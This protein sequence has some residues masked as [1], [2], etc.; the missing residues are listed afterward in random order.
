MKVNNFSM[1]IRKTKKVDIDPDAHRLPPDWGAFDEYKVAD[2][3][4]PSTWSNDGYFIPVEEGQPLWIDFRGNRQCAAILSIQRLNPI[5]GKPANLEDGLKKDPEQNYMVLPNQMWIDGY[6]NNGKVYQ[7]V[8]TTAGKSLAVNE[9]LLPPE[10][11]DSH[12]LGVAFYLPR[13]PAPTQAYRRVK[14]RFATTP[15]Y[16]LSQSQGSISWDA[17]IISDDAIPMSHEY[18]P[19]SLSVFDSAPEAKYGTC[20]NVH[21]ADTSYKEHVIDTLGSDHMD[22]HDQA[23]M[24]AGGRISQDIM[25]DSNTVDFYQDKPALVL[26]I[27]MALPELYKSIMSQGRKQEDGKQDKYIHSGKI[28]GVQIPLLQE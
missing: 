25:T 11:Q 2:W 19:R 13:N 16:T 27:Y 6:V 26:P 24:G 9:F 5:T 22:E 4:C 28:G 17:S 15:R 20:R 1:S 8:V 7:F 10:M 18:K 14:K 21:S 12:A 3:H 23:S